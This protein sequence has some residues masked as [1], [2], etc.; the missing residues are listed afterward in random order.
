MRSRSIGLWYRFA[1]FLVKPAMW[2]LFKR[3]WKGMDNIPID[4]GFIAAVNHNSYLDPLAYGHFQYNAHRPPRFLAK[5]SLFKGPMGHLL[6]GTGQIP[7]SRGNVDA[8]AALRNATEAV[9]RGE[10]IVFYPEGTLTRDPGMWPM[11]GRTGAARVALATR[12]PVIPVAQWG[13]NILLPPY[14]KMGRVFPRTKHTVL[15]GPPVDLSRFYGRE[16]TSE[17]IRE[18]TEVIMEGIIELLAEVRGETPPQAH[19]RRGR[20]RVDSY[21]APT[22]S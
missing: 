22:N 3:D 14:G 9:E 5:E 13:A 8:M 10:G 2:L 18:A 1:V 4:G 16:M 20:A 15:A 19:F 6:R 21:A 12:C 17:V 11:S 7:V